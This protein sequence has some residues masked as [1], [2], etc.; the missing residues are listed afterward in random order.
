MTAT[1]ARA[2]IETIL[3]VNESLAGYCDYTQAILAQIP[4]KT[5]RRAL[6]WYDGFVDL[7][8]SVAGILD[9]PITTRG[10]GA[11]DPEET[12]FTVLVF[13]VER[14]LPREA[15]SNSLAACAKRVQASLKALRGAAGKNG[16][17]T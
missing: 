1:E 9:V 6:G 12:P 10:T 14:F 7:M 3:R 16:S 5:G 15:W 8:V 11:R 13:G 2:Q 4:S 17:K